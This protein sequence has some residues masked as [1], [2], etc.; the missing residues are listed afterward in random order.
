MDTPV[1]RSRRLEGLRPERSASVSK[2]AVVEIESN[3][4]ETTEP[5]SPRSVQ[6]L[7]LGSPGSSDQQQCATLGHPQMLPEPCSG[8]PQPLQHPGPGMESPQRQPESNP[9]NPLLEPRPKESPKRSDSREEAGSGL[10]RSLQELG[11]GSP[12]HKLLQPGPGSPEP[13]PGLQ[14]PGPEPS[15]PP[16]ELTSQSPGTPRGPPESK[17]TPPTRIEAKDDIRAKKQKGAPAQAP[18]FKKFKEEK[19]EV[20]VIPKGK[21]K[22]GRVWKD[23]CK[24][25]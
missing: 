11:P 9:D 19:E 23:P 16:Q 13:F 25:R 14:A 18:A 21:P 3:A 8:S 17:T 7:G 15:G 12:K 1:R 20:L 6:L 2:V 24:K 22:S 10:V 4:E 5:R